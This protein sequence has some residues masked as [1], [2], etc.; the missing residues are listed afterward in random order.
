MKRLIHGRT[1]T[2][3]Y[4]DSKIAVPGLYFKSIVPGFTG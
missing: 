2:N 3:R 4:F 1:E